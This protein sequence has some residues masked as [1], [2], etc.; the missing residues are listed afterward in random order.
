MKDVD[1]I[2]ESNGVGEV[3]I[4]IISPWPAHLTGLNAPPISG[5]SE[6]TTNSVGGQRA[7]KG[8]I[9]VRAIGDGGRWKGDKLTLNFV[10]IEP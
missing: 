2:V 7:T 4:D 6:R 3:S 10:D 8:L 9:G 5:R 1:R